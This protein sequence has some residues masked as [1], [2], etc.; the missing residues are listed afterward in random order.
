MDLKADTEVAKI[1]ATNRADRGETTGLMEP[2][3]LAQG[4]PHRPALSDLAIELATRSAGF[5][6]SLG[7]CKTGG[8]E[9]EA[10]RLRADRFADGFGRH[11]RPR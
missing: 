11:P 1:K 4:S 3:V 2:L 10:M 5:R 9:A 6:R 8:V 7:D